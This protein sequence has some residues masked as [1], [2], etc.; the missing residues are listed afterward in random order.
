[1]DIGKR[2]RRRKHDSDMPRLRTRTLFVMLAAVP[3]AS[4]SYQK[5]NEQDQLVRTEWAQVQ[6]ALQQRNTVVQQLVDVVKPRTDG[7]RTSLEA[8]L[9]SCVRLERAQTPAETIHAANQQSAALA[10]LLAEVERREAIN[11]DPSFVQLKNDL[12]DAENHVA[13]ARMRYNGFVQQYNLI[14]GRFPGAQAAR[15][16]NFRDY[17]F[18]EVPASRAGAASEPGTYP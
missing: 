8:A 9:D 16:M 11:V 13:V 15:V 4:C 2:V 3:L 17:P 18:F 5:L 10:T 1:M 12:A 6:S 7:D 14:R